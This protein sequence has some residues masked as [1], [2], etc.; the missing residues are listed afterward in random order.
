MSGIN[1]V[2]LVG[3]VGRDPEIKRAAS[4]DAVANFS[5]AT[6]ETWKDKSG[7]RQERTEWHRCVAWRKLAEVIERYVRKGQMLYVEGKLQTR[8]WQDQNEQDRYSTEIIVDQ[9]QMLGGKRDEGAPADD[10]AR[11]AASMRAQAPSA[12]AFDDDIPF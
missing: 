12:E 5:L 10:R 3:H 2:I 7:E 8:K 11:H 6:S 4:G 9:M 1:R